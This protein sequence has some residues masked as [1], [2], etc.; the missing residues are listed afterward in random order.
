MIALLLCVQLTAQQ[1]YTA[2]D[3]TWLSVYNTGKRYQLKNAPFGEQKPQKG[4]IYSMVFGTDSFTIKKTDDT[5][6]F[7]P[8]TLAEIKTKAKAISPTD[9]KA[10]PPPITPQDLAFIEQNKGKRTCELARDD[11]KGK[12]VL[13]DFDKGCD[14]TYKCLQAQRAGAVMAIVIF[15]TN[16]KD[17]IAMA[18]GR[19]AD[20]LRIP[21]YSMLRMQ[22]DSVRMMLPSKVSLFTPRVQSSALQ[23]NDVLVFSAHKSADGEKAVLQWQNNTQ[24]DN[25]HFILERSADGVTYERLGEVDGKATER[26]LQTYTFEDG[27]PLEDDNLY[28]LVLKRADGKEIV[29][30]PQWLNFPVVKG[31]DLYPNPASDEVTVILK[32]FGGKSFD[33]LLYDAIGKQLYKEH[34]DNNTAQKKTLNLSTLHLT[35]GYYN[36]VVLH[37]GRAYSRRFVVAK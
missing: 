4:L 33:I 25:S 11:L 8:F 16:R 37:K 9:Y 24:P 17:S 34:I 22:G 15:D 20:S 31:F 13:I 18:K 19:Y 32:Q 26:S 30:E 23:R 27:L 5:K 28:R 14:P 2:A 21:C 3:S 29:S 12:V 1:G 6:N 7:K 10:P 35:E 36:L